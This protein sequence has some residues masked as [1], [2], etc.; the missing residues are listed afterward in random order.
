MLIINNSEYFINKQDIKWLIYMNY[1]LSTNLYIKLCE[2]LNTM[3]GN[4]IK[5]R[6]EEVL[7]YIFRNN[8][9]NLFEDYYNMTIFELNSL[10]VKLQSEIL[11]LNCEDDIKILSKYR[12]E[13]KYKQY[14][15]REITEIIERKKKLSNKELPNIID[16]TFKPIIKGNLCATR[17]LDY[18]K[19]LIY[20][21]N[22][23]RIYNMDEDFCKVAYKIIM[24]ESS[25]APYSG[26]VS[27]KLS[28]DNK[29]II[30]E[31]LENKEVKNKEK[32][33]KLSRET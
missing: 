21:V 23:R 2:M 4:Y 27:C 22:G 32:P 3:K 33:L 12:K 28:D 26:E 10:V 30:V 5:I 8:T 17:A 15:L 19:V 20:D 18:K 29:Y 25:D 7:Q 9:I 6:D 24:L 31:Q 13:K 11:D 16:V 1:D 14:L